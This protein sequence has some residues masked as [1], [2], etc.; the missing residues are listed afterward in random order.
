MRRRST[1]GGCGFTV[2]AGAGYIPHSDPFPRR[3]GRLR[4]ANSLPASPDRSR[5]R[6]SCN[7]RERRARGPVLLAAGRHA[8]RPRGARPPAR[9]DGLRQR[10]A[11]AGPAAHRPAVW[12]NRSAASSRT[13]PPYPCAIAATGTAAGSSAADSIQ[14]SCDRRTSCGPSPAKRRRVQVGACRRSC[15]STATCSRPGSRSS[16]SAATKRAPTTRCW[17]TPKIRSGGASSASA[18]RTSPAATCS[19][20]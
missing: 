7:G 5:A 18:S 2:P 20:T 17:R 9:R 6:T 3:F 16:S 14:S 4:V 19:A 12:R 11:G 10:G 15:C 8:Q 1:A 13:T